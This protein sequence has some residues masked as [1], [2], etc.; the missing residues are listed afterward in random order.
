[1]LSG[2]QEA[3]SGELVDSIETQNI[4]ILT[5]EDKYNEAVISSITRIEAELLGR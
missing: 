1:M 4:P 2:F 3:V 5:E